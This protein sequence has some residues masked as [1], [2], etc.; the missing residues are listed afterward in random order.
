MA[1]KRE[2]CVASEVADIA[3]VACDEIVHRNDGMAIG[4]VSIAQVRT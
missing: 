4:Q 3:S 2:V 1:N